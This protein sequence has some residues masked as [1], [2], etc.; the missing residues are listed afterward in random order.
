MARLGLIEKERLARVP[1][2]ADFT[3][4]SHGDAAQKGR[5]L[6]LLARRFIEIMQSRAIMR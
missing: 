5:S 4:H 6:S 2:I 1:R 3:R